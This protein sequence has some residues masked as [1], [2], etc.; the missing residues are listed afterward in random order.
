MAFTK[1]EPKS[2]NTS[3][4]FTFAN[5]NITGNLDVTQGINL[6]PVGNVSISG[7]TAGQV[8]STDGTGNL[9]W[10][11]GGVGGGVVVSGFTGITKDTFTADGS[12]VN[13]TLSVT[14]DNR[15]N[16]SVNIDGI[17]QQDAAYNVTDNILTFTGTPLSG[18]VIEVTTYL[19]HGLTVAGSN[20]QV[21]YNNNGNTGAS[22]NFT[23][24]SSTG[25]LQAS[26]LKGDG[27]QI[28]NI[29]AANIY[30]EVPS[31]HMAG[32]VFMNA[33]PNITSVGTLTELNVTGNVT[34][35]KFIGDGSGL[36]GV[37]AG[38]AAPAGANTQ[39]QFND[40]GTTAGNSAFTFNKTTGTLSATKFVG[41]G[42]LLT[43]VISDL[44]GYA[45]QTYVNTQI[46]NLVDAA[47]TTLN[48]L[49]ELA[50]A[51][52]DDANFSTTVTN[53][54]ANK[55]NSNAFTYAN[56]TGKP[57]LSTVATSGSYTDLLNKPTLFDGTYANLTGKPS[58]ATVATSGSYN[59]LTNKPTIPDGTYANLT[60]KPALFD[61]TYAN[62]TGKPTL[63]TVAT[64]GSYNDLTNKPTIPTDISSLTDTNNLLGASALDGLTDVVINSGTLTTGQVLKYD[65]TN[66]VNGTDAT[67]GTG[68]GG[69]VT[70]YIDLTDKP[71]IPYDVSELTDTTN[72]LISS[73]N[74]LTNKPVLG[75][76][77]ATDATAYA[78]AAQG[79]KA[80]SALQPGALTGYATETYVTSAITA[81]P[82]TDL[83]NYTTKTYVDG[84]IAAIPGT[85]LTGYATQLYVNNAIAAIPATDLTGYATETFVTTQGYLTSSNLIGYTTKTYVDS[86]IAAIPTTDLTG[87]ATETFVTTQGYLTSSNLIGYATQTY[88]DTAIASVPGA[89]LTG[90]ATQTYV[91]TQISNLVDTAPAALNTLNELASALGNDPSF[92][93]TIATSI[94]TKLATADFSTTANTWLGTKT[95]SNVAEGTN[96]YYTVARANTAISTR[97]N[98]AFVD[99]LGVAAATVTTNAQPNITSVG[100]LTG[101][102]VSGLVTTTGTGIKTGNIIDTSGTISITTHHNNEPGSVGMTANL[103]VT[104]TVTAANF[105]GNGSQLTGMYSNTNVS[106]FLPTYTGVVKAGSIKT[107]NLLYAN[108]NPWTLGGGSVTG[109]GSTLFSLNAANV[110]GT[111]SS[112]NV[113]GAGNINI[114]GGTAGQLLTVDSVGNLLWIDP[115]QG[116][117]GGSYLINGNSNIYIQPNSDISFAVS[118]VADTLVMSP[119]TMTYTGNIISGSGT[120]GNISGANVITANTVISLQI[121]GNGSSI[122][123]INGANVIGQVSNSVVAGTVYTNAQPN[124]TSV[125]TL[126]D[127]TVNGNVTAGHLIGEGG[128]ISNVNGANVYGT[129]GAATV[130]G[131]VTT[132]AQPNITS[133]GTL[134]NLIVNG[135]VSVSGA[136][137]SLGTAANLHIL[138]GQ[139]GYALTTDGTGNLGWSA[140]S[141]TSGGTAISKN[142]YWQGTV[143][144]NT[145]TQRLYMPD[146]GTLTKFYMN[147]GTAGTTDT[148][149]SIKKNGTQIRT[150][151][152][153]SG[154]ASLMTIAGDSLAANDYL[155]VDI[156]VAGA[157][158][159]DLYVTFLLTI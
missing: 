104:D 44:T 36:T 5:V 58:L 34:A 39:V 108:G 3:A 62:L 14:P 102:T 29:R 61:G 4:T 63:A 24:N 101:L 107:D 33:Q 65:G 31:S 144:V 49:N 130:A 114:G 126:T 150:A 92:A 42:S 35:A 111:F 54:L 50:A 85:D 51:L 57:T 87:Y 6:G 18:E 132:G 134:S 98:K 127:L 117:S 67:S 152:L 7:G 96:L 121:Q 143:Q 125:G 30:G 135:N 21:Q 91:N 122:S 105:V 106:S 38:V 76:A 17:T 28:G 60:G 19:A 55:L 115:Q 45:T 69:G 22:P 86:A 52:G 145:G 109:D 15:D 112:L 99:A 84:A 46:S 110:T 1:L 141:G 97:V 13:F 103:N 2:V 74:E 100:V 72:L 66:W 70:S 113:L 16:V 148:T 71:F 56:I 93:T 138:G 8:L 12:T 119:T 156:T 79:T 153:T 77:A 82:P 26:F 140:V 129:V 9:S 123:D 80:D 151:T 142:Y 41:D 59:D 124:I 81:I 95:T 159:V 89:D 10:A 37:T 157:S 88:V 32:T 20:T 120:G 40:N 78:T 23:F 147:L 53:T 136:N 133:I 68:G 27:Y 154:V 94:G 158:A 149:I 11:D 155:T 116:G 131:T 128:N 83:T 90:Y 64:S 146:A 73:Y 43:G 118:G 48:T 139:P 137:I 47:P 25:V 75:T